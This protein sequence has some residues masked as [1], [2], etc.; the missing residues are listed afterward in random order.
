MKYRNPFGAVT[1]GT[2]VSLALSVGGSEKPEKC[3]LRL[4]NGETEKIIRM[5]EDGGTG[6][7]RCIIEAFDNP[8]P[9]WYYFILDYNEKTIFY[10]NNEDQLGGEGSVYD[11]QPPS[12]QI[13]VYLEGFKTSEWFRKGA[14]YHIFVD[15]F[16]KSNNYENKSRYK[17]YHSDWYEKPYCTP[18]EGEEKYFPDDFFGGNLQGIIDRL[19]YLHDLGIT[20]IYLSPVFESR[21]NH[22]YDT[23]DYSKIDESFGNEEIFRKLCAEAESLGIKVMLDGVF[24]HTGDESIYFNKYEN[25]DS[26]GAYN[27]KE[28]PYYDWYSFKEYPDEYECWWDVLSMPTLNKENDEFRHF[29][30]GPEGIASK[31]LRNG[32]SAWRLDVADELPMDFLRELRKAVK[33]EKS[34]SIL[35]GEVWEDASNKVAYDELRNYCYGDSL[36]SV[37]NYPLRE[38]LIEFIMGRISGKKTLSI[39]N[40]QL[41]NY[42]EEFLLENMNLIGSHDRARIRTVL[43]GAPHTDGMTREDQAEYKPEPEQAI[44]ASARTKCLVSILFTMP[45]VP[46]IYY[47]DEAGLEGMSDPFNRSCYPWG[48]ED[49]DLIRFFKKITRF[50]RMNPVLISGKTFYQMEQDVLSCRRVL[51]KKE[52]IAIFNRSTV[53]SESILIQSKPDLIY[54]DL[55][56]REKVTSNDIGNIQLTL[57]PLEFLVLCSV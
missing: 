51:N 18:S 46:H 19:G 28:S 15:R 8:T 26:V 35:L 25:Y 27:S 11:D 6:M 30:N 53:E 9:L 13:T 56:T 42:P 20:T 50:R 52:V 12:Y 41:E 14:V 2:S 5:H 22:K 21:S 33:K 1:A 44:H 36:D 31:W 43:S 16:S 57:K 29:I 4:W 55:F 47:G 34:D 38:A 45:G 10:G 37:M 54:I 32:A 17:R 3:F 24:S 39:L 40:S 49:K 23:A 48:R 7:Y